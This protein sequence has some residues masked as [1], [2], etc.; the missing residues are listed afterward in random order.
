[1]RASLGVV[2]LSQISVDWENWTAMMNLQSSPALVIQ[3]Q[4]LVLTVL[5]GLGAGGTA[6]LGI[7][8]R[9]HFATVL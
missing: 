8:L 3:H 4:A 9:L 7:S 1:M 2:P 6:A 5:Y